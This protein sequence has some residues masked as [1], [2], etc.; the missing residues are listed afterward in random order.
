MDV[1]SSKLPEREKYRLLTELMSLAIVLSAGQL[2]VVCVGGQLV[3]I[4]SPVALGFA[5][6]R[7]IR[8]LV[9]ESRYK[10]KSSLYDWVPFI[11]K[12]LEL[13]MLGDSKYKTGVVPVLGMEVVPGMAWMGT[14]KVFEL[15]LGSGLLVWGSA[16][17]F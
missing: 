10:T 2:A 6:L 7:S 4:R 8:L 5:R 15:M 3:V 16:M 1:Q 12:F 13:L 17:P 11:M 9:L 14:Q